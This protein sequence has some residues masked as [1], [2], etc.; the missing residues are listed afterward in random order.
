MG[1]YYCQRC[2]AK[3]NDSRTH[4]EGY[5]MTPQSE[6]V[7]DGIDG[8]AVQCPIKGCQWRRPLHLGV[9]NDLTLA[10]QHFQTHL[11][12]HDERPQ[13]LPTIRRAAAPVTEG[14][15]GRASTMLLGLLLVC[16]P[17]E[18]AA[19]WHL[20][21]DQAQAELRGELEAISAGGTAE[22]LLIE[23]KVQALRALLEA[24]AL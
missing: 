13:S 15:Q 4:C 8:Q 3:Q 14:A 19:V 22:G 17:G 9:A 11:V 5:G 10:R 23:R 7:Q 6:L 1:P 2:G 24:E 12:W 16:Q 20:L 18:E 21:S